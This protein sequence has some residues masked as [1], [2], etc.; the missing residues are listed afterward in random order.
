MSET[1]V[2]G[3]QPL[4][5][6]AFK[7]VFC[8]TFSKKSLCERSSQNRNNK[9]SSK[10]T[11]IRQIYFCRGDHWSPVLVYWK[12]HQ[13]A[14][15]RPTFFYKKVAKKSFGTIEG[16]GQ[17]PTPPFRCKQRPKALPLETASF[18]KKAG[19]KLLLLLLFSVIWFYTYPTAWIKQ[20]TQ[21]QRRQLAAK[22]LP[23][24]FFERL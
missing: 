4:P 6:K 12:F 14:E 19:Q 22:S 1:G 5:L 24:N 21:N 13:A 23:K 17:A 20:N 2:R 11:W 15:S 3:R 9:I 10:L 16:R 7:K 8:Q 18:L